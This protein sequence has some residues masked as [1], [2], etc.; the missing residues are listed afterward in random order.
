[1]LSASDW[2]ALSHAVRKSPHYQLVAPICKLLCNVL[3]HAACKSLLPPASRTHLQ[4]ALR[5]E[6]RLVDSALVTSWKARSHAINFV[7]R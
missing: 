6:C 1:M 7:C 2:D 5:D 4:T 3:S